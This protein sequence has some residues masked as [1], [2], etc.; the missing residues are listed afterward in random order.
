MAHWH[1]LAKLHMHSDLTLDIMDGVMSALGQQLREFKAKGELEHHSP[2]AWYR[3]TDRNLFV[4]QLTQIERCQA[5]IRRIGD[6]NVHCPHVEISELVTSPEAHHHIGLTQKYPVHIGLYLRSHQGDPAV[7]NFSSKLKAHLLR[8]IDTLSDSLGSSTECDINTIII[9]DDRMYRHNIARFNYTTYDV[10][11]GQD[12]VNPR[13]SHCNVMHHLHVRF[14]DR[15]M[16]MRFHFGLSVGHVYSHHH[17][18]Q[19]AV[20]QDNI[21]VQ[22]AFNH[23]VTEDDDDARNSGEDDEGATD[24]EDDVDDIAMVDPAEQWYGSSQE[25]LLEQYEEMYESEGDFVGLDDIDFIGYLALGP[26][27]T[28]YPLYLTIH[29]S[30]YT[31]VLTSVVHHSAFETE[32]RMEVPMYVNSFYA[33]NVQLNFPAKSTRVGPDNRFYAVYDCVS[34]N[35]STTVVHIAHHPTGYY[36]WSNIAL[37]TF[38]TMTD[39]Y[40]SGSLA[41]IPGSGPVMPDFVTEADSLNDIFVV[42]ELHGDEHSTPG[43]L[44]SVHTSP[45]AMSNSPTIYSWV[46][47]SGSMMPSAAANTHQSQADRKSIHTSMAKKAKAAA[48]AEGGLKRVMKHFLKWRVALAYLQ[49]LLRVAV[50]IGETGNPH[51]LTFDDQAEVIR[52]VWPRALLRAKINSCDLEEVLSITTGTP[53]SHDDAN[54]SLTEFV[55]DTKRLASYSIGHSHA[56][57]GLDDL[58]AG[59]LLIDM[60]QSLLQQFIRPKSNMLP[61]KNSSFAWFLSHQIAKEIMWHVAFHPTRAQSIIHPFRPCLYWGPIALLLK[62]ETLTKIPIKLLPYPTPDQVYKQLCEMAI[63]LVHEHDDQDHPGLM[64]SLAKLCNIKVTDIERLG[65][66]HN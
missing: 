60:V 29:I 55:S 35:S 47:Y 65:Q 41:I 24:E 49:S 18:R 48:K 36:P 66:M 23:H 22:S 30:L 40:D 42:D 25:S 32:Q 58:G 17:A 54:P 62:Y 63:E 4:K 33:V 5:R 27:P 14:V 26:G 61:I 34:F 10:C 12:V 37:Q 64:S 46:S 13:T 52:E 50:C 1:G 57:F 53:M 38:E 11:R 7:T 9:K 39:A 51:T 44:A 19:V 3:C 56:G 2:K 15:D 20:Q 45:A 21:A 6:R 43:D 28:L 8:R 16:L 31:Y 59:V